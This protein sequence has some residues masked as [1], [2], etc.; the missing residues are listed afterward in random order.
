MRRRHRAR[1]HLDERDAQPGLG[2][3]PR[4]LAAGHAA[5]DD[6]DVDV[7]HAC[8]TQDQLGAAGLH[9]HLDVRAVKPSLSPL[10][11]AYA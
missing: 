2:E 7:A 6:G 4:G 11:T 1:L 5:A 8:H 3:L 9:E 10:S